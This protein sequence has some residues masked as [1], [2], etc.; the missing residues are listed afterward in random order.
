MS[1][2]SSLPPLDAAVFEALGKGA[3]IVDSRPRPLDWS[4]SWVTAVS[5]EVIVELVAGDPR[6]VGQVLAWW[7]GLEDYMTRYRRALAEGDEAEMA[8]WRQRLEEDYDYRG[9]YPEAVG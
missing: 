9:P 2:R 8:W 1:Q 7:H 6:R 5:A 3:R 4:G